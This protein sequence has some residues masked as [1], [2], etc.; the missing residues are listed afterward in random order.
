MTD[1]YCDRDCA[2]RKEIWW[3]EEVLGNVSVFSESKKPDLIASHPSGKR[4]PPGFRGGHPELFPFQ[5]RFNELWK[6]IHAVLP[7][8]EFDATRELISS[9]GT[10]V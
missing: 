2:K 7:A 9:Q 10:S 3:C 8:H 5:G 4:P 6:T 1:F